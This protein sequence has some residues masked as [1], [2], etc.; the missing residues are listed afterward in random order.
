MKARSIQ[1]FTQIPQ[2]A[3]ESFGFLEDIRSPTAYHFRPGSG[4]PAGKTA[5]CLKSGVE[6]R[7]EY[8]EDGAFPETAFVSLR[9]LLAA[10][11]IQ[12]KK[13]AYPIRFRH[14]SDFSREEYEVRITPKYA[15]ISAGDG[16]GLRRAIYFLEDRIREAEGK[17]ATEGVWRRKPFIKHRISRCFFGPTNRP[18]FYIDEL[19]DDVD[20]YP[21]EYLD[22]LAHEGVNGLWLT[23]YFRDL[24][25]SIFPGRG[26][27]AG[28]RFAKL[29]RT[30]ARCMR[31][32]IRIYLF[33]SEPKFFGNAHFAI[34][35]EDSAA[36]PELA[37]A[38]V[39]S[40]LTF[41]TSTEA[42]KRYLRESLSQIF[43][44]VPDLGGVI[45]IMM[46]EDNG[47]CL[48][49]STILGMD[50]CPECGKRDY[51]DSYRELAE[52]F[53]ETIRHC[54]PDAEF[55]G[56]FYAPMQRDGSDFMKRLIHIAEKWPDCATLMLNFESGGVSYQLDKKRI[57]LDYSLAYV[58]PSELFAQS[59]R[60]AARNGAKLQVGC[61]H[62]N[63]SVPFIPVPENL[64]DKYRFMEK[65]GVSSVMQ[66]WY[67]GNYPGL[68]NKAAGELAFEPFQSDA[69]EFLLSLARPDWGKD[70]QTVKTAWS[71]FAQGYRKFPSNIAFEWFGPLHHC[72]A[73]PL[74]LFPVDRPIAPSWILKNF[75]ETS[76]DRIGECL[77]YHHTLEEALQLCTQMSGLW[78]KGVDLLQPLC[79]QYA[80]NPP[81]LGDIRLTQAIGLQMKSTCNLLRFYS[82]REDMFYQKG[83]HLAAMQEIVLDEISNTLKMKEL[84]EKDSRLGY[85]SEAEGYL[86]FPEKLSARAGLLRELLDEDFP[87]FDLQASW[88]DEYTGRIPN[89]PCAVSRP[90]GDGTEEIHPMNGTRSWSVSHDKTC[91]HV[92]VCNVRDDDFTLVLE[93]RRMWSPLLIN[94][95]A[96]GLVE[97]NGGAFPDPPECIV[98]K[99]GK[100]C[101]ID[102]P[103][104]IFEGFRVPG[105]PMRFNI[106]GKDFHWI[107]PRRWPMRLLHGDYNPA[108]SAWLILS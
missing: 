84:C 31:Y 77:C 24:P 64:Y 33:L 57:V 29:R 7:V 25:S 44:A 10:K 55:I 11:G 49:R 62:E 59:T 78:Q 41:C 6:I 89:G 47:S 22:K 4:C 76:G 94:V 19:T 2:P 30:V 88:I 72:I 73:W 20:Y 105:F 90:R 40:N 18:P 74:Y 21:E 60:K 102:I 37:V 53:C 82:L 56:W 52:L 16:D 92:T 8:P 100:S 96:S 38:P 80:G 66:C 71:F 5:D 32:G 35:L 107:D 106:Y 26:A 43:S 58:G 46:G 15:E 98:K 108:G 99:E 65:H 101:M 36:H 17:S 51:A 50:V 48:A 27:D 70:A 75:P 95:W 14:S 81:R 1:T 39:G 34:P 12:E 23:M 104:A 93:P 3:R 9:K 83:D 54:N 87:K 42:G 103:L 86:F 97:I 45:N 28:K 67:F 85:H 91:L 63:A 69:Q 79:E 13:G 61:S 68:M